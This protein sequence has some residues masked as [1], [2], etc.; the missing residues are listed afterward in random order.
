MAAFIARALVAPLGDDGVP[1]DR[2][3]PSF[4]DVGPD[5]EWSWCYDHVE[6]LVECRVVK[7]YADGGYHPQW[8]VTRAQMPVYI[9]R[10][11]GWT[12]ILDEMNTAGELFPDVGAGFW[13]GTAIQACVDNEVVHGYPD[14]YYR[15]TWW[16]SR[17]Q[18]AVYV[19]RAFELSM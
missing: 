8:H 2:E 14:G 15:P 9:A 10:A 17:D 16:V 6:Y 1:S 12:G 19:A 5:G 3:E 7:G 4:W 13:S 18:M 11:A